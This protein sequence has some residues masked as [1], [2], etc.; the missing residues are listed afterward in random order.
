MSLSWDDMQVFLAVAREGNLS[1]AARVLK[2]TQPTVGR[3]L[4]ALEESHERYVHCHQVHT[5]IRLGH[6]EDNQHEQNLQL[7]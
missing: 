6:H 5:I 7:L 3:R 1:A 2:V 4:K